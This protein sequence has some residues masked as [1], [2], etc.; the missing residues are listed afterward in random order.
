MGIL[1]STES[2]GLPVLIT[3]L[4]TSS[5]PVPDTTL[6]DGCSLDNRL[7]PDRPLSLGWLLSPG[8]VFNVD[9]EDV[10]SFEEIFSASTLDLSR[11]MVWQC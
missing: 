3:N 1:E 10:D 9:D 8:F 5:S 6:D 11:T 4:G 2:L 7:E